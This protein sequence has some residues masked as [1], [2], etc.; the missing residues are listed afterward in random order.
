MAYSLGC[1]RVVFRTVSGPKTFRWKQLITRVAFVAKSRD[2]LL[3]VVPALG[4]DPRNPSQC[5]VTNARLAGL[6]ISKQLR[7]RL[8]RNRLALY[9]KY[10]NQC[11]LEVEAN[12]YGTLRAIDDYF[13][14]SKTNS[15]ECLPTPMLSYLLV[16]T[17]QSA[18][19]VYRKPF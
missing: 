6:V 11:Q 18:D 7:W 1:G 15:H 10:P 12:H 16:N 8:W 14:D 5:D 17:K 4:T 9:L 3:V 2:R 13:S 19:Y